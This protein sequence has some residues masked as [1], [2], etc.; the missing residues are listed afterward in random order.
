VVS[1]DYARNRAFVDDTLGLAGDPA[2]VYD[3]GDATCR[4]LL[5]FAFFRRILVHELPASVPPP[6]R[7]V[8]EVGLMEPYDQFYD[9]EVIKAADEW[10]ELHLPGEGQVSHGP[11]S[12]VASLNLGTQGYL[13]VLFKNVTPKAQALRFALSSAEP[14]WVGE[15]PGE[16]L[17][18]VRGPV[19]RGTWSMRTSRTSQMKRTLVAEYEAGET[20]RGLARKYGLHRT[21]VVRKLRQAGV[22]TGQRKLS[23]AFD[24]VAEIHALREQGMSLR[25]IANRVGASRSSVHRLLADN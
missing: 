8:L 18:D 17:R 11:G 19:Q 24:L 5:A 13:L 23:S 15:G 6:E 4:R 20:A 14:G 3:K 22:N 25:G 7:R 21:T 1:S 12:T 16:A 2:A 9:P 10:A